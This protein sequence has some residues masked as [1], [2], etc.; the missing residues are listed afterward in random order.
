[1]IRRLADFM[2]VDETGWVQ[3]QHALIRDV[4]YAGLPFKT[5]QDLHARVGD[6]IFAA[7]GDNPEEFAELLSLHYFY[8][9]RWSRAWLFSRMAGDRA[10]EIYANHEAAAFY[11][12]ALQSA[13]RLDW[14]EAS[15]RRLVLTDL[16]HV[17]YE[18]GA[19]DQAIASL[20]HALRLAPD[21]PIAQANLRL[22]MARSYH[23]IG[24]LSL[25]L[26][27][28]ALGLKL[29]EA[30][31]SVEAKKTTARL[32][33]LR[34]GIY[35]EQFRPRMALEVGLRAVEE[36]EASGESE[37]LARAY[38]NIDEA[39]QFL[40]QRDIGSRRACFGDLRGAR[41]PPRNT[42]SRHQSRC[43]GLC[44]RPLG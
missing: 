4:A 16:A 26:R 32:R 27:E 6:S 2:T 44:R 12:R 10:K 40:G 21:D 24:I 34:A 35:S 19:F 22:A 5:R 28:T 14:V 1:M 7:C 36:A 3:F 29:L 17:Q 23:L 11:E 20:R 39:Y 8:A 9:K 30:E 41:G 25:A 38:T 13:A 33:A 31:G 15:D 18:S 42:T 37:A 43:A